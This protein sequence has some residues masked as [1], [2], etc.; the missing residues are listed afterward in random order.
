MINKTDYDSSCSYFQV[1]NSHD[2]HLKI[3]DV[4]DH[5]YAYRPEPLKFGLCLWVR[6]EER[7]GHVTWRTML[8]GGHSQLL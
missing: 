1:I 6:G 5:F 4:I 8:Y 7:M 2:R 3:R